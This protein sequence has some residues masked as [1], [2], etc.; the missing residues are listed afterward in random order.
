MSSQ[1]LA[2][3]TGEKLMTLE[4][5]TVPVVVLRLKDLNMLQKLLLALVITFNEQGLKLSNEAIA[6]LFEV[7][8]CRV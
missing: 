3:A 6:E 8:H 5:I 1:K 7:W 4:Y 2:M